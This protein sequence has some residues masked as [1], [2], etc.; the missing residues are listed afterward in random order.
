MGCRV[1]EGDENVQFLIRLGDGEKRVVLAIEQPR[2]GIAALGTI[3]QR[4]REGSALV[5]VDRG[6]GQRRSRSVLATI[7]PGTAVSGLG[8]SSDTTT[9]TGAGGCWGAKAW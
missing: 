8:A 5:Q 3:L 9:F 4:G 7:S 6:G 2:E 1:L